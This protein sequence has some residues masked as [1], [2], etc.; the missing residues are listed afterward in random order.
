MSKIIKHLVISGGGPTLFKSIGAVQELQKCSVWN[1][2]NIESIYGTSAGGILGVILCCKF[3]NWDIINDYIIKRPWHEALRIDIQ[4]VFDSFTKRGLFDEKI[5]EIFFKPLF[6]AKDISLNITLKEFYELTGVELHLFTFEINNFKEEDISYLTHPDL[7]LLTAIQMTMAL[8]IIISPVCLNGKCYIDGGVVSNYPLNHCLN[9]GRSPEE[10]LSFRNNY[11]N[12]DKYSI[13][14][15]SSLLDYIVSFL[16]RML[17]HLSTEE[18]QEKVKNEVV[19]D[20][21]LMSLEYLQ[22]V[23]SSQDVRRDFI[24]EGINA[25]KKYFSSCIEKYSIDLSNN[26]IDELV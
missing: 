1:I 11:T 6:A 4:T 17:T 12:I 7:R 24:N 18:K 5:V 20:A 23:L 10:I 21:N 2:E 15:N 3:D 26:T 8:P 13:D 14:Q 22:S 9:H 16:Y 19:Y 25:G